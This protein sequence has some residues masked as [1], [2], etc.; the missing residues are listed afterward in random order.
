MTWRYLYVISPQSVQK[1]GTYGERLVYAKKWACHM[2]VTESIVTK[3]GN[4]M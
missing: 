4:F 3:F 1:Y 2:T